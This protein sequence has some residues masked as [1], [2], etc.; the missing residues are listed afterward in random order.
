MLQKISKQYDYSYFLKD[1]NEQSFFIIPT[2]SD[3]VLLKIKKVNREKSDGLVSIPI[4]L[5]K[6]FSLS[7]SKPVSPVGNLSL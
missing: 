6:L 1:L 3:E 7:L 4:Q 2:D 5:L